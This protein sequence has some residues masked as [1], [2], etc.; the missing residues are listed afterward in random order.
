MIKDFLFR[1][2]KMLFMM[3]RPQRK[4]EPWLSE[5][6]T[7]LIY[8]AKEIYPVPEDQLKF[9]G[10]EVGVHLGNHCGRILA[11]L[12]I[13]QLTLVDPWAVY[14]GDAD[15]F[16]N[17]DFQDE[18]YRRVVERFAAD[19]RVSILRSTSIEASEEFEDRSLDFVYIDG[20]H[21]Y[22]PVAE[23]LAAWW[24]KIR[25][26]GLLAGDDYKPK[27]PGVMQAVYEFSVKHHIPLQLLPNDQF[28]L[29][30]TQSEE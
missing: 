8:Q 15:Y 13:G 26:R 7:A 10:V 3:K 19:K 22:A 11:N 21:R 17:K 5:A 9:I 23:D 6:R 16:L 4:T 12:P 1:L 18:C 29:Y 2:R 25:Y 30:K 24:P 28:I 20:D 14:E 27:F